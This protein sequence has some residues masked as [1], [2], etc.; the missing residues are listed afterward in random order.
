MYGGIPDPFDRMSNSP[1]SHDYPPLVI[2]GVTDLRA[3]EDSTWSGH[4]KLH[5]LANEFNVVE[6]IGVTYGWVIRDY[7]TEYYGIMPAMYGLAVSDPGVRGKGHSADSAV[8]R[9]GMV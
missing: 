3:G 8:E 9:S 6:Y 7:V 2:N 1:D 4:D 5:L